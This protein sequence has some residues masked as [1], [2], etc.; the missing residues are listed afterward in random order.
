MGRYDWR[1]NDDRETEQTLKNI[2]SGEA[3]LLSHQPLRLTV[4]HVMPHHQHLRRPVSYG[5]PPAS[6]F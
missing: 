6:K 3:E 5:F 4:D 2:H 1:R